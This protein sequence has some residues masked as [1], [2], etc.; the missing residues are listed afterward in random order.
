M[1]LNFLPSTNYGTQQAAWTAMINAADFWDSIDGNTA[2]VGGLTLGFDAGTNVVTVSGYDLSATALMKSNNIMIAA[3]EKSL[4]ISD[5][6]ATSGGYDCAVILDKNS[7][8]EWGATLV[9]MNGTNVGW[10]IA[11]DTT[12][13]ALALQRD[14]IVTATLTQLV[15][16][17]GTHSTWVME[18]GF[19]VLTSPNPTYVGKMELNGVK[20][21]MA[22][23]A[24]ISYTG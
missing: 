15:P 23:R 24:A 8:D 13:T 11:P 1:A 20:Y 22:G 10:Y 4:I 19:T 12:T 2:T 3:S 16:V 21:V 17:T 14:S 18:N 5:V 7:N 9:Q 6:S